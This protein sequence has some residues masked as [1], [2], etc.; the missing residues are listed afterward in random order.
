METFGGVA[1]AKC[2]GHQPSM[3]ETQGLMPSTYLK[4]DAGNTQD[5][6]IVLYPEVEAGRAGFQDDLQPQQAQGPPELLETNK[7]KNRSFL[8]WKPSFVSTVVEM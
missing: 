6:D 2:G 7:R 5:Y 4:W 1:E 3:P 8:K